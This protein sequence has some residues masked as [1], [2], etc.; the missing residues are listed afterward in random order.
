MA[1]PVD[2]LD[3]PVRSTEG[4]VF[5]VGLRQTALWTTYDPLLCTATGRHRTYRTVGHEPTEL[6]SES[7][8]CG[9]AGDVAHNWSIYAPSLPHIPDPLGLTVNPSRWTSNRRSE[10]IVVWYACKK[11]LQKNNFYFILFLKK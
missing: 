8:N 9:S 2:L 10:N 6:T 5:V 4:L 7:G 3:Q 1:V 11:I